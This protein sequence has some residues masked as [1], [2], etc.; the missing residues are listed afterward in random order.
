MQ[1]EDYDLSVMDWEDTAHTENLIR[2]PYCHE[3]VD[4]EAEHYQA[5]DKTLEFTCPKC[6]Q[7]FSLSASSQIT[8][9][10]T[11]KKQ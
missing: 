8:W 5:L 7:V 2:C 1:Y 6:N 3:T 9:T 4:A 10:T 11:R